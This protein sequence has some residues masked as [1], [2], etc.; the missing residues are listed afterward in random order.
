M[1]NDKTV[2]A[3][4]YQFKLIDPSKLNDLKLELFELCLN[5]QVKG[6]LLIAA[7]GLNGTVSGPRAGIDRLKQYLQ[8]V[9]KF[10][11]LS[12]KESF[13]TTPPFLR[14]KVK[15]KKEIVTIGDLS[16]DPLAKVGTYVKGKEWNQLLED[17][18]VFVIDTRNDYEVAIGKFKN[19]VD[20]ETK[21]FREFPDYVKN[22]LDPK[23]H[24]KIAM[25]CTGGIRCEK[26]SSYMLEQ[27]F[28]EVYHLQG[29]ILKYIEET[30]KDQSLWD[31]SCFVFDERVAVDHDLN[32]DTYSQCY[33]C[34]HPLTPEEVKSE[35]TMLGICCPYCVDQTSLSQKQRFAERQKQINLAKSRG[36]RHI[37]PLVDEI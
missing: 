37:A 1:V 13:C 15:I 32:P 26:A 16:V 18:E 20:P 9:L 31:G 27:G 12:Y 6:T 29:G 36:E 23:K 30:E 2:V 25:Y 5:N 24:K 11:Q 21:N 4:L 14:L 28:E 34:R 10:D 33:G 35:K 17:P 22:N 19:A 3:A 7:E 8:N